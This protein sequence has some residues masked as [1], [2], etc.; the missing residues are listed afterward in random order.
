MIEI[1]SATRLSQEAF[2]ERAPLGISMRRLLPGKAQPEQRIDP[3]DRIAAY[4]AFLND[5]PLAETYNARIIASGTEDDI[6]VFVHDDVWIEDFFLSRRLRDGLARFDVLG[7]AGGRFRDAGQ[8]YW[9]HA[10]VDGLP[11]SSGSVAQG[12]RDLISE[13]TYYGPCPAECELM[14]GLFL[15]ARRSVLQDRGVLFDPQFAFHLYD[16]D[17]CR[18]A[19][20]RGLRLGTWPIALTHKSR[21]AWDE[22]WTAKRDLYLA[23]WRT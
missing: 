15:A 6:L 13:V 20:E 22:H 18:T 5:R 11:G 16:L 7:V 23:K 12:D 10:D 17:F 8:V 9:R 19:R 2:L 14:D 1:V 3:R 21:G 4:I